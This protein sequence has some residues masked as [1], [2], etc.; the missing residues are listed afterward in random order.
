M[1]QLGNNMQT[2]FPYQ[3]PV[4][5]P[6]VSTR[7]HSSPYHLLLMLNK[8]RRSSKGE[9][10]LS[11]MTN[12]KVARIG[13]YSRHMTLRNFDI[14]GIS[15]L[16]RNGDCIYPRSLPIA[17]KGPITPS[18][19]CPASFMSSRHAQHLAGRR[20]A[21]AELCTSRYSCTRTCRLTAVAARTATI[22]DAHHLQQPHQNGGSDK[23]RPFW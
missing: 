12:L 10:F 6:F 21:L 20:L 4:G 13:T 2:C 18:G 3:E 1:L 15:F 8:G 11:P 5:L 9:P 14:R 7:R 17:S 16:F 22:W 23:V 19:D